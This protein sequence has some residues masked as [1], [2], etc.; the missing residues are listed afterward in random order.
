M[1]HYIGFWNPKSTLTR[2]FIG[3]VWTWTED[4]RT[5][6]SNQLQITCFSL[7]VF[8]SVSG[9]C[10]LSTWTV[11]CCLYYSQPSVCCSNSSSN[12]NSIS[13]L[14]VRWAVHWVVSASE[15][16]LTFGNCLSWYLWYWICH[17]RSFLYWRKY[18]ELTLE[19]SLNYSV[20]VS[21]IPWYSSDFVNKM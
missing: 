15:S 12:R 10:G 1:P 9:R 21:A 17:I 11:A 4:V 7:E 16:S 6:S 19:N 13:G 5:S 2:I 3:G 14:G 8:S 18:S 20:L